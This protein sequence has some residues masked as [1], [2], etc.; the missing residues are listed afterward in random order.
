M[1]RVEIQNI[2]GE[3]SKYLKIYLDIIENKQLKNRKKKLKSDENYE[4]LANHHILPKSLFPEFK[5]I[6]EYNWNSV[7]LTMKE[8][9]VVY[10]YAF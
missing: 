1:T 8:H 7:L 3:N 6:K 10:L 9:R 2:F 5:N 4:Y